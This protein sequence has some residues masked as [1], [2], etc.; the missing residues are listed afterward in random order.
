MNK[1]KLYLADYPNIPNT[2]FD[3]KFAVP[4]ICHSPDP[5]QYRYYSADKLFYLEKFLP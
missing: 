1:L 3:V 5:V 2:A 4:Q